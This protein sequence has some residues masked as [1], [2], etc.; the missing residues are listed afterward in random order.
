MSENFKNII[1]ELP[2]VFNTEEGHHIGREFN[3]PCIIGS[4]LYQRQTGALT[5]NFLKVLT[6][7]TI[8]DLLKTEKN[9]CR[10]QFLT[11]PKL[12]EVDKK[13]LKDYLEN[14][15]QLEPFLEKLMDRSINE[16][17]DSSDYEMDKQSR[18]DIFTTLVAKKTII[19]KFGFPKD[20]YILFHK[21]TGIFHFD[22][23]DK[24][25]FIGGQ[26]DTEGGLQ[27]SLILKLKHLNKQKKIKNLIFGHTRKKR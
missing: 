9:K 5:S 11:H 25:G 17:I 10:I 26:N 6:K 12:E 2:P 19:I 22:W 1:R 13:A 27:L 3:S 8:D 4:N 23:G 7:E 15:S 16:F 14:K 24:I 18:L 20:P 21:K